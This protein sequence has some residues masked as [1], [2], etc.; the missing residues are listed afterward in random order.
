LPDRSDRDINS[1]EAKTFQAYTAG[2]A[3]PSVTSSTTAASVAVRERS[4]PLWMYGHASDE[5][6]PQFNPAVLVCPVSIV[7]GRSAA[8]LADTHAAADGST[9]TT[10]VAAGSGRLR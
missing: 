10:R 5:T 1:H 9:L 2:F 3:A 6:V 8:T 4:T 7:T